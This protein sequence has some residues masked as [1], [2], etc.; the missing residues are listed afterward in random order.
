MSDALAY[1][2]SVL[3]AVVDGARVYRGC[4]FSKWSRWDV[5]FGDVAVFPPDVCGACTYRDC[6]SSSC[7]K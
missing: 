6:F 3:P 4:S 2:V 7:S 5:G 1:R